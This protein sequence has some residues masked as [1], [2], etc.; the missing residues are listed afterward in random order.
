MT[1]ALSLL[2]SVNPQDMCHWQILMKEQEPQTKSNANTDLTRMF[3]FRVG[4]PLENRMN[5]METSPE[6][7]THKILDII[8]EDIHR[9]PAAHPRSNPALEN[10]QLSIS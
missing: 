4:D 6:N 8:S 5:P 2:C 3:N 10:I 7:H 1:M 9:P